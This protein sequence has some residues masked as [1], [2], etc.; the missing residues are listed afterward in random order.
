MKERG[1]YDFTLSIIRN[2]PDY[3]LARSDCILVGE[4]DPW[5]LDFS[6]IAP[7]I[8]REA[9]NR[10][11]I[12]DIVKAAQIGSAIY[13]VIFS[14]RAQESFE[15]ALAIARDRRSGLRL[16]LKFRQSPELHTIPWELMQ[17]GDQFIA[18]DP[19]TPIVRYLE[20]PREV[21]SLHIAP[22][23]RVL[24]TTAC[25]DD[26]GELNLA[27]E[28]ASIRAALK[29]LDDWVELVVERRISLDRLRHILIRAQNRERPFH[30]WHHCGHGGL[31]HTG[32][33]HT[34]G[35]AFENRGEVE[36]V[37]VRQASILVNA[38][39]AMRLIVL[40]VC[41]GASSVGLGPAL[42][43]LGVPAIIGFQNRVSDRTALT[44]ARTFYEAV[45]YNPV[46]VALG[47]ARLAL[48]IDQALPLDWA[49][50]ILFLRT[51]DP[52]LLRQPIRE[53]DSISGVI[54]QSGGVPTSPVIKI[55][56]KKWEV[57]QAQ[58]IGTMT[59][60]DQSPAILNTSQIEFDAEHFTADQ[61][62]QIGELS[63]SS[64][65]AIKQLKHLQQLASSLTE[66]LP[67]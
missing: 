52:L 55:K 66:D 37:S 58:F 28:E 1:F 15:R 36:W 67:E 64:E 16:Q 4:T 5:R 51:T 49:L 41:Y 53:S 54:R 45:L 62:L 24:F 9:L 38:C 21:K 59:I 8:A 39:D 19:A 33:G 6:D 63:I 50:P 2:H 7:L 42:A 13:Q 57:G 30:V 47:Q 26:M 43:L 27:K 22:P 31:F 65:D 44:F 3:Y 61:L 23:I 20:Q 32:T 56:G 10:G 14:T 12:T 11:L 34:F 40:N 18:S 35:L 25:P 29:P 17:T 46:D 60:G 48:A